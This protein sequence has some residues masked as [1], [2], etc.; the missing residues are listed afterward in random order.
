[1]ACAL[2][3]AAMLVCGDAAAD[4]TGWIHAGSGVLAWQG[5][6][7]D[8]LELSPALAFDMGVGTSDRADYIFGGYFRVQPIIGHGTDLALFARFATSAFQTDAIGFA[9]DAGA[10]QRWWGTESTGF[11]GQGVI[12]GPLGLQLALIGTVGSHDTFGFGG[13]LGIDLARLTIYRQHLLDWWPNP[14]PTDAFASL[15][16]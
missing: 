1:M 9:L 6:D 2:L 16:Y 5:G 3:L 13:I 8:Q 11:I 12:G 7:A 14:R 10:Y 15:T 4:A